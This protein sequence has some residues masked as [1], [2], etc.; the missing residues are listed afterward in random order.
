MNYSDL[1]KAAV[2]IKKNSYSPYSKFKVGAAVLMDNGKIYTGVNV[3]NSSL[4]AT[5]CAERTAICNAVCDGETK[6]KAIAIASDNEEYILPCGICRQVIAE[7]S[8]SDTDIISTR[9]NG[10][11]KVYKVKDLIPEVFKL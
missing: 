9:R 5:S 2:E 10:E 11:Y 4:G 8:G 7:F 3:E 1:I 6:I